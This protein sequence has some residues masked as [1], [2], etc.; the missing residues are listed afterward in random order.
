MRSKDICL[1]HIRVWTVTRVLH[2]RH[3][4]CCP[5]NVEKIGSWECYNGTT[6]LRMITQ[7]RTTTTFIQSCP[8]SGTMF[9]NGNS[10]RISAAVCIIG[11]SL[12]AIG[13]L[14]HLM[15][16]VPRLGPATCEIVEELPGEKFKILVNPLNAN[17]NN[18][19]KTVSISKKGF[20][21]FR[22]RQEEDNSCFS[23]RDCNADHRGCGNTLQFDSHLPERN[24]LIILTCSV[25][26]T[27]SWICALCWLPWNRL[28]NRSPSVP[29]QNGSIQSQ[30]QNVLSK[31]PSSE[32]IVS[33]LY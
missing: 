7:F 22:I 21:E 10:F 11:T 24:V 25:V 17:E 16:K 27:L 31:V 26:L 30:N 5:M 13:L 2:G 29:S 3:L 33:E 9:M 32:R 4:T 15:L 6:Q 28:T 1:C 8:S 12:P 20:R 14:L 23:R 18:Y 19:N